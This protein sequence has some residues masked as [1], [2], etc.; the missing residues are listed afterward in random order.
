MTDINSKQNT[1]QMHLSIAVSPL[2]M[3]GTRLKSL[4]LFIGSKLRSLLESGCLKLQ[5]KRH[6]LSIAGYLPPCYFK[7][8]IKE[9]VKAGGTFLS[10]S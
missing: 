9:R 1:V 4:S 6:A 8:Y 2:N 3:L 7:E 5:I 10:G